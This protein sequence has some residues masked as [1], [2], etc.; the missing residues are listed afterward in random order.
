[1]WYNMAATVSIPMCG[2]EG[3]SAA[4]VFEWDVSASAGGVICKVLICGV[5]AVCVERIACSACLCP[6]ETEKC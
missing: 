6:F 3:A 2:T 1:M 4:T 5:M